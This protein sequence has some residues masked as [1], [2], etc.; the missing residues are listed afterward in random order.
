MAIYQDTRTTKDGV[1]TFE[2]RNNRGHNYNSQE[3]MNVMII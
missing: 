1:L 2:R 3:Q